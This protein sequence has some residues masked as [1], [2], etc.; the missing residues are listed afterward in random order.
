M[1]KQGQGVQ[2][3]HRFLLLLSTVLNEYGTC[4]TIDC[5]MHP[6]RDALCGMRYANDCWDA[7]LA[8]NDSAMSHRSSHFHYNA[9][10]GEEER[11]PARV[12]GRSDQN[13]SLLQ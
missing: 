3:H 8:G 10:S 9:T 2:T 7:V 5:E 12:C 6:A 1:Q 4:R 13:L 11:R